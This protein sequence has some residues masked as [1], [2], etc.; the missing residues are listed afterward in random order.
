MSDRRVFYAREKLWASIETLATHPGDIRA[1][2]NAAALEVMLAPQGILGAD[3]VGADIAWL[4]AEL[5]RKGS[6]SAS[7][8]GMHNTRATA[9]ADRILTAHA[10]LDEYLRSAPDA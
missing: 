4:N 9:I 6:V 2:L 7:L 3:N 10:K 1:R 8:R 5:T